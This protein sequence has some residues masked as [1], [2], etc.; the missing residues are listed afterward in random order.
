MADPHTRVKD[1]VIGCA[2][3]ERSATFRGAPRG[4]P[5]AARMG[6]YVRLERENGPGVGLQKPG[7]PKAAERT[8]SSG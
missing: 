3:P 1:I 6:P 4:R 8:G 7:E 5:I 2:G